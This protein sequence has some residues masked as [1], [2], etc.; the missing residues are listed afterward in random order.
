MSFLYP[1]WFLLLI[2]VALVFFSPYGKI[3]KSPRR[4][5][6]VLLG[7]ILLCEPV[8]QRS[9]KGLD[10][11]VLFDCSQSVPSEFRKQMNEWSRLLHQSKGSADRLTFLP[12]AKDVYEL[13]EISWK[14]HGPETETRLGL[15]LRTALERM[16]PQ[17]ANRILVFS[18]GYSTDAL[19]DAE[20]ELQKRQI[21]V[22]SRTLEVRTDQDVQIQN[23]QIPPVTTPKENYLIT[24]QVSGKP[25]T[26]VPYRVMRDGQRIYEATLEL[27]TNL[28]QV[29]LTDRSEQAGIAVYEV[30]LDLPRDPIQQNNHASACV[31]VEGAPKILV[32]S[33]FRDD[34]IAASLK[35][36][37]FDVDLKTIGEN[38]SDFRLPG[39]RAIWIHQFPAY[40]ASTDFWKALDFQVHYQGAGL[41]M[42]GGRQS[43][44]SGGFFSS[45]IGDLLPVSME[46][47]QDH[48]KMGT[49]LV[50]SMDR[51]GSMAAA[52]G[53]MTKMDMAND[54]CARAVEMLGTD[55]LIA[56]FAVDTQAHPIV[57]LCQIGGHQKQICQTVRR[58]ESSGGGIFIY[59]ASEIREVIAVVVTPEE[60]V[61][62]VDA[63]EEETKS[64][65]P[66]S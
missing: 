1:E 60:V 37:G 15:A 45:P 43:Y 17:S 47:R 42:V 18:D 50:V 63:A 9:P 16:N 26:P 31:S 10:L 19:R 59:E 39:Y 29:R 21:S 24:F 27:K 2:M 57:D 41:V 40:A 6:L 25:G 14:Y 61:G 4:I 13:N 7:I 66:K 48:R 46:L 28:E 65:I 64:F 8:V 33:A 22:D 23:L 5:F 34:P 36:Q 44:A 12:F 30:S 56:V 55:D 54:G 53:K 11:W 20:I 62:A 51:S 49:S 3:L 38:L 32:L 52:V 35:K 58:I